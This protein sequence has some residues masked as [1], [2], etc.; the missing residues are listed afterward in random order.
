LVASIDGN[1]AFLGGFWRALAFILAEL[2]S[3]DGQ[4]YVAEMVKNSC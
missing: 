3:L 2:H 1:N 4:E